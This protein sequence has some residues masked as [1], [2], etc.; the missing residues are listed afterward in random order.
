[1]KIIL[2]ILLCVSFS[3]GTNAQDC[4]TLWKHVYHPDRLKVIDSCI[5]ITGFVNKIKSEADGDK[6]IQI[7]VDSQYQH[8]LNSR[9]ITIQN[10]CLVIEIVCVGK[11]TQTDVG[12]VC[13]NYSSEVT[14]PKKGN[15]VQVIGSYIEDTEGNHGWCEIHPVVIL[16]ILK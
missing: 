12:T 8:L 4:H 6:H 7:R 10:G 13:D 14:I 5:T 15:R 1:M 9:N 2:F 11:I 3:L 16:N